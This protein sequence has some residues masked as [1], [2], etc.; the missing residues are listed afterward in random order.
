M[1]DPA[2]PLNEEEGGMRRLRVKDV[3]TAEV[4]SVTEQ[5][6]YKEIV[7]KLSQHGISAVPVL[8]DHRKVLGI[9]SEADLI[10]K[11][12]FVGLEPHL[13]LLEGKRRRTARTKAAGDRAREL[14]T[15][16]AVSISA[17]AS[18]AAAARMMDDERVKRL[19]VVDERG[20]LVGIVSR[21][22]LLRMY[23]RDDDAIVEEVREQVLRRTMWIEPGTISVTAVR[24]VVTLSG[25]VDR[26]ST[27]A[28]IA[29]LCDGVAG[30]VDVVDELSYEYDD[31]ADLNRGNLSG[32]NVWRATP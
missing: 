15:A 9:V 27:A 21:R 3:M 25:T 26:R 17:D 31:T 13:N 22:D 1:T 8:D 32:V 29:Q 18:L 24:G 7:E 30:V 10:H 11:V 12:E 16:P 19:P 23:L 4:V 20:R 14:M 5:A 2:Y 6:D 28:I